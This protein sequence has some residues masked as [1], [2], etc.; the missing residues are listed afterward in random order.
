MMN[1][2]KALPHMLT[3]RKDPKLGQRQLYRM[4][5]RLQLKPQ[6]KKTRGSRTLKIFVGPPQAL[7]KHKTRM[8]RW[9]NTEPERAPC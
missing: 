1:S 8:L 2:A 7:R 3:H 4:I 9:I 5:Y 6:N